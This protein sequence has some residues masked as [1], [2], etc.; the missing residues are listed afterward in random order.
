MCNREECVKSCAVTDPDVS[1]G[2]IREECC[3]AALIFV[4]T[5]TCSLSG[6][7]LAGR[8]R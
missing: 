6:L 7:S 8:V 2:V 4:F 5:C 1:H 3:R